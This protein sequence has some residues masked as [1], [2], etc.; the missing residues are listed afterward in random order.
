MDRIDYFLKNVIKQHNLGRKDDTL[1]SLDV[2][3]IRANQ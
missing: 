3:E 2:H 1:L